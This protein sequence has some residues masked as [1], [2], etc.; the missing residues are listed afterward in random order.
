M[1]CKDWFVTLNNPQDGDLERLEQA[2]TS[3]FIRA[4]VGGREVGSHGTPHIHV[5]LQLNKRARFST[6]KERLGPRYS[7]EKRRGSVDEAVTYATKGGDTFSNG[8]I[9]RSGQRT[10]L[11]TLASKVVEGASMADISKL[12]P[13]SVVRYGRGLRTLKEYID[14]DKKRPNE[15]RTV[16]WI[17]GSS[18]LGKSRL[19]EQFPDRYEWNPSQGA[20]FDHYAGQKVMHFDEFRGQIP[21]SVMLRIM[22]R[23]TP[24]LQIKGGMTPCLAETILV[25]SCHTPAECYPK[26]DEKD[27]LAQLMRRIS[28]T[29]EMKE[30]TFKLLATKPLLTEFG[31]LLNHKFPDVLE[32]IKDNYSK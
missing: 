4:Y 21:Y 18:G 23:S 31:L 7:I 15:K 2:F 19:C 9:S 28:F 32:R 20:W 30:D 25:T 17:Y 1:S 12:D 6:V 22:D 27:S 29:L 5:L 11:D 24:M 16:Y 14:M 13:T 10:D 8:T 3:G 26:L